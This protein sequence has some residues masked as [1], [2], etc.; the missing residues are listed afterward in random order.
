MTKKI[1]IDEDANLTLKNLLS[2]TKNQS[3]TGLLIGS[4]NNY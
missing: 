2:H 1:L 4:V 3:S